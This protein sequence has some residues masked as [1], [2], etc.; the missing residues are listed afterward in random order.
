MFSSLLFTTLIRYFIWV[1]I[2]NKFQGSLFPWVLKTIFLSSCNRH[3]FRGHMLSTYLIEKDL[4]KSSACQQTKHEVC[5]NSVHFLHRTSQISFLKYGPGEDGKQS[6]KSNLGGSRGTHWTWLPWAKGSSSP[7]L[8]GGFP[9]WKVR[10]R[11][12]PFVMCGL[13]VHV[14]CLQLPA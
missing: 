3:F 14:E 5:L 12:S 6:F 13:S 10:L 7:P 11:G 4:F 1:S 9:M 8:S 2:I